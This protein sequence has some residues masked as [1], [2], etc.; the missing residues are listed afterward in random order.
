[1]GAGNIVAIY[2]A[3][4]ATGSVAWQVYVW[5]HRRRSHV[6]VE[7]RMAI[8]GMTDEGTL[9]AVSVTATNRSDHAVWVAGVGLD[10]Q[11]GSG[12]QLHFAQRF[13]GADL[14]GVL[15]PHDSS[16]ALIEQAAVEGEGL[17]I[18]EPVT[19]WARLATGELV[20]FKPR[21]LMRR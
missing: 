19:A 7:A 15:Q 3:V 4:L 1:M 12:R 11:D 14:P 20:R 18:L 17:S 16:A 10:L 9:P 8:I 5:R 21:P 2:A 6:H 13:P